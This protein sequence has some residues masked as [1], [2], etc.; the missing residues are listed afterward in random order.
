MLAFP[1]YKA[2]LVVVFC[3]QFKFLLSLI[4]ER[5][6]FYS[7]AFWSVKSTNQ[8][9]VEERPFNVW[10]G[11]F[12]MGLFKKLFSREPSSTKLLSARIVTDDD[13]RYFVSFSKHHRKL[14]MP[15]F[16]RIVLH[17]YAKVLFNF[18]PYD[19]E[20]R[21][22]AAMLKR[23]IR[24]VVVQGIQRDSNVLEIANIDD[25]AIMVSTPPV[26]I[27]R[28]IVV[29]LFFVDAIQRYMTT[30]IPRN[31]HAKH[32]VFSVIVLLQASLRE[33]D[34]EGLDVLNR[35]LA[36]M[37]ETYDSGVSYFDMENQAVVPTQAY[38]AAL[39][40]SP[41]LPFRTRIF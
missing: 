2:Y 16:V 36:N 26:N 10:Q 8:R 4:H 33:L 37:N 28:E 39:K 29:T 17:Y 11:E 40:S 23:M 27:P 35:S 41:Y 31:A 12:A 13:H 14:Q 21:R 3:G 20:M 32:I 9:E 1:F 5:Q 15:E 7:V 19:S 6:S 34:V 38:L 18:D 22:S 25:E 24:S 30:D